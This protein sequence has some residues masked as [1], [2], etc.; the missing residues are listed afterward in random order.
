MINVSANPEKLIPVSLPLE[1]VNKRK[2]I[3]VE[4]VTVLALLALAFWSVGPLIEE[5]GLLRAFNEHGLS[6]LQ[7]FAP[8]IPM[9]PL[10]LTAYALQWLLGNGHVI[11]VALGTSLLLVVR[12][13]V[14]RWA[15]S[16]ILFGYDR[17][18][19]AVLGAT[20]VFWP[21][22]WLGRYGSAQL[23][24]ILFFVALGFSVRLYQRWSTVWA[25][26]C[27]VSVALML[28]M[29]QGLTLCLAAIPLASLLW[30]RVGSANKT[31]VIDRIISSGRVCIPLGV[32]FVLYGIYCL[33]VSSKLGNSGYEGALAADSARLLTLAGFLTHAK[34]AYLTAFGKEAHLLPM[35]L[36]LSFFICGRALGKIESP[37]TRLYESAL[38]FLLVCSLPLLSMIYVNVLHIG[39]VDRVLF[40]VSAGFVLLGI[41][42]LGR[43]RSNVP[44]S[45]A[46]FDASVVVAVVL[47]SSVLIAHGVKQYVELQRSV[48]A[49]TWAATASSGSEL[50]LI[51]DTTGTLGDVYTFLGPT[52]G[53]ASTVLGR[54]LTANIC[55]PL[56]VDRLHP[57]A[58]RFPI[59]TTPR[60]EELPPA[61]DGTLILTARWLGGVLVVGP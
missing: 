17:W 30:G 59:T 14:V 46:P 7:T 45:L 54:K 47:V 32:G 9:R 26:G 39:D 52:L 48:I 56:S 55:T 23:S 53:D 34:S 57:V 21:G 10:H 13:F 36:V 51:Q 61:A 25:I 22:V 37:R 4:V 40:P 42:L 15:V 33:V 29:Y 1:L 2:L 49:Q 3:V 6:Y 27:A 43:Y 31:R 41:T 44:G 28:A 58:Q 60:C 11:G 8:S 38:V 12:Y 19:A 16:P 35:L 20:L 5:W 18:V 24:A 50:V